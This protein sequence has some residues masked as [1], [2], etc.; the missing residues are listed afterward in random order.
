MAHMFGVLQQGLSKRWT[1]FVY[2]WKMVSKKR[3][4]LSVDSYKK[5]SKGLWYCANQPRHAQGR[6]PQQTY[7]PV[8]KQEVKVEESEGVW[9]TNH[10]DPPT[11][12]RSPSRRRL[13]STIHHSKILEHRLRERPHHNDGMAMSKSVLASTPV[14]TG[15]WR[16]R[17]TPMNKAAHLLQDR[18]KI[19]GGTHMKNNGEVC[20]EVVFYDL[21]SSRA[22]RATLPGEEQQ[23]SQA[24]SVR[25]LNLLVVN[26][27]ST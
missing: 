21:R 25:V 23:R 6:I 4:R 22:A 18:S 7:A 5:W 24:V 10:T 11:A 17:C 3:G 15:G 2:R 13:R 19:W 14:W 27:A 1:R 8:H 26:K 9:H 16:L 12:R 20:S